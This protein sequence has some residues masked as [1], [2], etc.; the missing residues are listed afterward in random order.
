[1]E[2]PV[3]VLPITCSAHLEAGVDSLAVVRAFI[4]LGSSTATMPGILS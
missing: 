1:M 3:V 2:S 4:Q